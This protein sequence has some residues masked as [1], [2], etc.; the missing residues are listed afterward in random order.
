MIG[1]GLEH[2]PYEDKLRELG[3]FSLERRLQGVLKAALQC[4]QEKQG[5]FLSEGVE[6][7]QGRTVLN[8]KR[9][10]FH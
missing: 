8:Q 2:L 3:W 10:D 5:G 4:L 7:G 6:T 9:G 1:V